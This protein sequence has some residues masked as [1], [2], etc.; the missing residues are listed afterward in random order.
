MT[1]TTK[2][3]NAGAGCCDNKSNVNL[4]PAVYLLN[5]VVMPIPAVTLNYLQLRVNYK[6]SFNFSLTANFMCGLF[7]MSGA[8]S[9]RSP[10]DNVPL[11]QGQRAGAG[12]LKET[13]ELFEAGIHLLRSYLEKMTDANNPSEDVVAEGKMF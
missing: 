1:L 9:S 6:Q 5:S 12:G 11:G 3:M 10:D 13:N 8:G 2:L 4:Y 7:Q